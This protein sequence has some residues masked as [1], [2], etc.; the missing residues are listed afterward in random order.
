[1][2]PPASAAEAAEGTGR[3]RLKPKLNLP[4][5]IPAPTEPA[6]LAPPP[7]PPPPPSAGAPPALARVSEAEP[8]PDDAPKF[9]LR[10]KGA[11]GAQLPPPPPPSVVARIPIAP[12]PLPEP[13]PPERTASSMPPMSILAAPLP[14]PPSSLKE[15]PP[16]LPPAPV[17]RLSLTPTPE[18]PKE[19]AGALGRLAAKLPKVGGKPKPGASKPPMGKPGKVLRRR[20]ALG[21]VAK[22]GL[23]V[24]VLGIGIGGYYSFRIFFPEETPTVKIKLLSA[25]PGDP[26]KPTDASTKSSSQP[27]DQPVKV[28]VPVTTDDDVTPTPTPT[29]VP[30][31]PNQLVMGNSNITSDVKVGNTPIDAAPAASSAFRNYVANATIGGVFQGSP[32]RAL[33]N[34]TIAREGQVIDGSLG[35]AFERID[36]RKKIIFFKDYTGAE[37]SKNY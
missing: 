2:V 13:P 26:K 30:S 25:R 24:V 36:A 14:P 15:V 31:G 12:E 16:P 8:E 20:A 5:T 33:I 35:I 23:L 6:A 9:K 10:P 37:V 27:T 7:P 22:V 17:P 21:P 32:A 29:P 11:A 1:M 18:R 19:P 4:E 3:L 28:E 34:G